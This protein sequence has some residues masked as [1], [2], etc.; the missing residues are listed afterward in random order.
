MTETTQELLA[1]L[2]GFTPGPWISR[3]TSIGHTVRQP[4]AMNSISVSNRGGNPEKDAALIAA[5]PTLHRIATEQAAEIERLTMQRDEAHFQFKR[6]SE[7]LSSFR[8]EWC[9]DKAKQAAEIARLRDALKMIDV[10]D[11]WAALIARAALGEQT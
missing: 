2:T 7:V 6:L 8:Y 11:G 5:A 4:N 9:A 3:Y 10:G 1:R